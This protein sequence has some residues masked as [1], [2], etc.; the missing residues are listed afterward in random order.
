M[1][2]VPVLPM[3]RLGLRPAFHALG[4]TVPAWL[5][6]LLDAV[7]LR[8][9]YPSGHVMRLA[10]IPGFLFPRRGPALSIAIAAASGVAVVATGGHTVTDALGGLCL[11][12]AV[13]CFW[14]EA[15]PPQATRDATTGTAEGPRD[16]AS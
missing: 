10:L 4:E 12:Q 13:L 8:G 1:P 7:R 3:L 16:A 14:R 5:S 11:A 6:A 15:S 2:A 9:T